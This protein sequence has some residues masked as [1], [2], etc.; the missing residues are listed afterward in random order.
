VSFCRTV[1]PD[2]VYYGGAVRGESAMEYLDDIGERV[3]H[4]FTI[5]NQGPW[6]VGSLEV[7]VEW[8]FQVANNKPQGKWLL[9]LEDIPT[10]EGLLYISFQLM[11][12]IFDVGP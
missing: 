10:V 12:S 8:P 1:Y 3:I 4:T 5:F 6:K 7:H 2:H 11:F 9:Y